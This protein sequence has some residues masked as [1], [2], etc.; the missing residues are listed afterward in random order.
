MLPGLYHPSRQFAKVNQLKRERIC[1]Q[2]H[3]HALYTVYHF[4]GAELGKDC[5]F[6]LWENYSR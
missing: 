4:S 3:A 1:T 5:D 6:E 2:T